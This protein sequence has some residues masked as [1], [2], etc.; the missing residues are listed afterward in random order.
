MIYNANVIVILNDIGSPRHVIVQKFLNISKLFK[1]QIQTADIF[2]AILTDLYV[3]N[4]YKNR[5]LSTGFSDRTKTLLEQ[6]DFLRTWI[7][8]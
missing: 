5:F 2:G 8:G 3:C 6:T 1:Y 4:T 7:R